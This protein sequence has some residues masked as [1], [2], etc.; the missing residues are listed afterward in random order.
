MRDVRDGEAG[1]V[2]QAT[3][4]SAPAPAV[5]QSAPLP[6]PDKPTP[7]GQRRRRKRRPLQSGGV[8]ATPSGTSPSAARPPQR[9]HQP[10]TPSRSPPRTRSTRLIVRFPLAGG[11]GP[12][13][14]H[15]LHPSIIRDSLNDALHDRWISAVDRSRGGHLVLSTRAPF[16]ARQL[17]VHGDVIWTVLQKTFALQD[18]MR[19]LFEPDD[20][21]TAIVVH[22]VPLPIWDDARAAELRNSFFSEVCEWNGLDSRTLKKERFLCTEDE[23]AT[24]VQGSTRTTPQQV[25]VMLTLSDAA[26]AQRLLRT[27]VYWQGSHCRASIYRSRT[28]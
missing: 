20:Q 16:T 22:R 24:R 3:L 27:G 15:Q 26:A 17:A 18:A 28:P 13:E 21:W 6:Q 11:P 25:S 10:P 14:K 19:P 4:H 1:G 12:L 8:A 7:T 2:V 9:K 23:L 5:P